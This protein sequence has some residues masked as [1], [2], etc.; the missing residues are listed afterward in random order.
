MNIPG[1]IL[2]EH[3]GFHILLRGKH[4]IVFVYGDRGFRSSEFVDAYVGNNA[5]DPGLEQG[6]LLI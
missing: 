4:H 3:R 5:L 6:F 2:A 1:C